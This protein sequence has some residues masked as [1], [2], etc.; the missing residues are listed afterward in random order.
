[1]V[2]LTISIVGFFGSRLV[3]QVDD[4]D[5][6]LQTSREVQASQVEINKG[7]Q[8]DIDNNGKEIEK[9]KSEVDR[10]KET[11]AVLKA[12]AGIP[13]TQNHKPPKGGF[14]VCRHWK[15]TKFSPGIS[16]GFFIP[17]IW[18]DTQQKRGA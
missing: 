17:L 13:L 11:N 5:K 9:L 18:E 10:L 12:K 1:M 14:L 16:R 4:M 15:Q 2:G 8:R 6:A 7:L 3:N